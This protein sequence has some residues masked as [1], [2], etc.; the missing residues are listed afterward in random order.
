M[1]KDIVINPYQDITVKITYIVVDLPEIDEKEPTKESK[2]HAS[3]EV[4]SALNTWYYS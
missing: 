1:E 2:D 4:R 3:L